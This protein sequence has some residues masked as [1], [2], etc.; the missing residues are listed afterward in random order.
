MAEEN[1][2]EDLESAIRILESLPFKQWKRSEDKTDRTDGIRTQYRC[3]SLGRIDIVLQAERSTQH[4]RADYDMG[5]PSEQY[6]ARSY[7]A[8]I[9][10]GEPRAKELYEALEAKHQQLQIALKEKE[11]ELCEK[12]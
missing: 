5:I 8:T 10:L 6:T 2:L 11:E 9:T 4:T 3:T 1:P 7:T 12:L